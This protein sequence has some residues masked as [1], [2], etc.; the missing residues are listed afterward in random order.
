M[1]NV[2]QNKKAN[3]QTLQQSTN[4]KISRANG[5]ESERKTNHEQTHTHTPLPLLLFSS[6]ILFETVINLRILSVIFSRSSI[7]GIESKIAKSERN[8]HTT[9][10]DEKSKKK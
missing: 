4:L 9:D 10:D 8:Q 2:K 6:V 5:R 3:H 7:L 1:Q